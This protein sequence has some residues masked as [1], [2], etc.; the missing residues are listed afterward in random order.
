MV[1]VQPFGE[2]AKHR[3]SLF[4]RD[5]LDHQLAARDPEREGFPLVEKW[6]QS[7]LEPFHRCCQHRVSRRVDREL[8]QCDRELDQEIDELSRQRSAFGGEGT[9]GGHGTCA[10]ALGCGDATES[11]RRD[12]PWLACA[13]PFLY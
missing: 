11:T 9:F 1:V 12:R 13:L 3:V 4:R 6:H 5:S 2:I 10:A 7:P 8:L